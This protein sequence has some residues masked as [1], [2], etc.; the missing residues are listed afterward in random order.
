MAFPNL[1]QGPSMAKPGMPTPSRRMPLPLSMKKS[2]LRRPVGT[3][4]P[5][6]LPKQAMARMALLAGMKG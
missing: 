2:P 3:D 1:G 5:A 4:M 6:R